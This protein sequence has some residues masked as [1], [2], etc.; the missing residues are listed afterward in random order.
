MKCANH[1]TDA[2][3]V[4]T[5]CGR[6]VCAECAKT[7]PSKRTVCSDACA[8]ALTQGEAALQTLLQKNR[9]TARINAFFY[10][11]CGV[12]SGAGAIAA[13]R[14]LPSPFLIW[15]CAGCSAVFIVAGAWFLSATKKSDK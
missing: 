10:L 4:C 12:L 2:I 14:Y 6:A 5:H 8:A 13:N 1:H 7:S 15:F 3:A 11:L 9:Q